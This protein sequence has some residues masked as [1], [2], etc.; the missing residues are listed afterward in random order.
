[1]TNL[2]DLT[3]KVAVTRGVLGIILGLL[4]VISP[5]SA[6]VFLVMWGVFLLFDA[7][8]WFTTAFARGQAGSH[9]AMS[10]LLGILALVV[11]FFAIFRPG[12]TAASL[13]I[14]LGIWLIVRGIGSALVGITSATGS[15]RWLVLLGAVL[16]IVLGVLFF[17]NPLGSALL[18][19]LFIGVT[20]IVWGIVTI[21]LGIMLRQ[22]AKRTST[23]G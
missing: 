4:L 18:I 6:V 14:F 16:D 12:V 10:V 9:R 19:V 8:G 23:L 1:M 17:L 3:W 7:I 2:L 11:A 22:R 15:T 13:V 5:L 21:A 20:L